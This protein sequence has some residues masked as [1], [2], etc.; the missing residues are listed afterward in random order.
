[1]VIA[2]CPGGPGWGRRA[3]ATR[4]GRRAGRACGRR[5][6]RRPRPSRRCSACRGD[7]PDR[8]PM[9]SPLLR[10]EPQQ[11]AASAL[12]GPDRAEARGDA[13]CRRCPCRERRT[14]SP[15]RASSTTIFPSRA[16]QRPRPVRLRDRDAVGPAGDPPRACLPG[17]LAVAP[18]SSASCSTPCPAPA[19][20]VVAVAV[21]VAAEQARREHARDDDA[22]RRRARRARLCAARHRG[23]GAVPP[24]GSGGET[25]VS[26]SCAGMLTR[27]V[28]AVC[29]VSL[30]RGRAAGDVALG[31]GRRCCGR[32][33][34]ALRGRGR[35]R[36][37]SGRPG[38]ST[39]PAR[40]RPRTP[41]GTRSTGG[42]ALR[43]AHS[44]ASS[45]SRMYGAPPVSACTS[46]Q[47]S[48]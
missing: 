29:G 35:R 9:R 30:R 42:G 13:R 44:V 8:A 23:S 33:P 41:R 26:P 12:H 16:A 32:R 20:R 38:P 45:E 2:S 48:A 1:M 28:A 18:V 36:T 24:S 21:T 17:H 46:T 37:G 6:R 34:R 39:A 43:C 14:S 40:R 7:H 22:Q 10:A 3:R 27:A 15:V 25:C 31:A 47:P 11:R 5:P 4:R 19:R